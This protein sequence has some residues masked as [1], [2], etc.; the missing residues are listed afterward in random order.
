MP[1][2]P[3]ESVARSAPT[4]RTEGESPYYGGPPIWGPGTT[5][6]W[7]MK[8]VHVAER[9]E[10]RSAWRQVESPNPHRLSV[11]TETQ[12]LCPSGQGD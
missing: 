10:G 9:G 5:W 4:S 3:E 2:S 6:T 1:G 12:F 11:R 8:R 7:S